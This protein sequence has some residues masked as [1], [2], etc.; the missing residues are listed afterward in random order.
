MSRAVAQ[1]IRAHCTHHFA[2]HRRSYET[3]PPK[4]RDDHE[5]WHGG[6]RRYRDL[7]EDELEATRG[8]R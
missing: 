4:M 1:V 8:E 6:D 5:F 7:S 3:P 2:H